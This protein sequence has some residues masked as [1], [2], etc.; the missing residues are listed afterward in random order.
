[1]RQFVIM[2]LGLVIAGVVLGFLGRLLW[3]QRRL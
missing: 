3:P 1:M 2:V